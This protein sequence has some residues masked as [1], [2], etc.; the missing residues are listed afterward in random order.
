M[1]Y[2]FKMSHLLKIM[3]IIFLLSLVLISFQIIQWVSH[4]L[5]YE[6]LLLTLIMSGGVIV[7]KTRNFLQ[8]LRGYYERFNDTKNT[9]KDFKYNNFDWTHWFGG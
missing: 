3:I 6:L 2:S 1:S 4:R 5:P 9:V 7:W 8:S